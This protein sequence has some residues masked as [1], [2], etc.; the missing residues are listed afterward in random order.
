MH[1][2]VQH[3]GGDPHRRRR[4]AGPHTGV[5]DHDVNAA[6][7]NDRRR[8]GRPSCITARDAYG[9][10]IP[11]PPP[12]SPSPFHSASA[13][14]GSTADVERAFGAAMGLTRHRLRV[15]DRSLRSASWPNDV[16]EPRHPMELL[17]LVPPSLSDVS[18]GPGPAPSSGPFGRLL[19]SGG[20][21]VVNTPAPS[22]LSLSSFPLSSPAPSPPLS[23]L[24]PSPPPSPSSPPLLPSSSLPPFP[25]DPSPP[26]P[27][28]SPLPPRP[29]PPFSPPLLPPSPPSTPPLSPP[30]PPLPPPPPP[31]PPLSSP[32]P[33]SLLPSPPSRRSRHR[34]AVAICPVPSLPSSKPIPDALNRVAASLRTRARIS[35]SDGSSGRRE[36]RAGRARNGKRRVSSTWAVPDERRA[37]DGRGSALPSCAECRVGARGAR[38]VPSTPASS[39][40]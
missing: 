16:R 39:R 5:V 21:P 30:P 29:L 2:A 6:E 34:S 3:V 40:R 28:P 38:P 4:T 13:T 1:A 24:P 35:A 12:S 7:P 31:P 32:S 19:T 27:L 33:L 22:P 26:L 17:G 25:L 15:R 11:V 20:G 8:H 23:L 14:V 37:R 9:H 18:D 36:A 10:P